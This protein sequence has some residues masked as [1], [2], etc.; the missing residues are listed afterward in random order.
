MPKKTASTFFLDVY[1]QHLLLCSLCFS[2]IVPEVDVVFL[3][4]T[5]IHF[6]YYWSDTVTSSNTETH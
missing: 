1:R 5:I 3:P 4:L 6:K 2:E